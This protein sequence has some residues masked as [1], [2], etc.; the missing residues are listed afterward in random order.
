VKA[1]TR[2]FIGPLALAYL[3]LVVAGVIGFM[4]VEALSDQIEREA[5]ARSAVN[6]AAMNQ[7]R[8]DIIDFLDEVASPETMEDEGFQRAMERIFEKDECP[9]EP[10]SSE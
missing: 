3:I 1:E 7:L 4:R 6:C 2:N 10:Q 9:P 5:V 8:G